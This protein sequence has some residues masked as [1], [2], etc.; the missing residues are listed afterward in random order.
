M[1]AEKA[2]SRSQHEIQMKSND[3]TANFEV[4]LEVLSNLS[5]R[6]QEIGYVVDGNIT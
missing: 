5:V 4:T 6:G 2:G 1:V 3:M